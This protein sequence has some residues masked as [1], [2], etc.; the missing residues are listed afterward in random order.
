MQGLILLLGALGWCLPL[1]AHLY[2]QTVGLLCALSALPA[3][4][5]ARCAHPGFAAMYADYAAWL[6]WACG[7]VFPFTVAARR[8][9]HVLYPCVAVHAWFDLALGFL[10]PGLYV[11]W[12]ECK[13]RQQH[14][15]QTGRGWDRMPSEPCV[16]AWV[17]LGMAV[18]ALPVS[19]RAVEVSMAFWRLLRP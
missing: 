12:L 14:V 1:R 13:L 11:Q 10:L 17:Y 19:W 16:R 7:R 6:G 2:V 15:Q 8:D 18:V 3:Q 5:S 9:Q 4:C